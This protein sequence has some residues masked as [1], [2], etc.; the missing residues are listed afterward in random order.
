MSNGESKRLEAF[1][2]EETKARYVAAYD[3]LLRKWPIG[4]E[5]RDVQ[6]RYGITHVVVSGPVHAPPLVLL[7]AF[8]ATALV[9]RPNVEE[10]SRHF[11]VYAVDVVGQ[12]GKS[13]SCRRLRKRRDF[14]DW[15]CDLL[16]ALGIARASLVG[17]SYGGF[18]AM[19][20]A[21]L[22]PE[23]VDR[24]V[25]INPGGVFASF[26]PHLLKSIA[27]QLLRALRLIPQR[28]PSV[29][30]IL[31]RNV[32]FGADEQQWA[33]LV[34]LLWTNRMRINAIMPAV[35]S[36]AELQAIRCPALLLVGDDELLYDPYKL[37]PR[38]KQRMPSLEAEIVAGA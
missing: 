18:I 10:L 34:S 4:Y 3:A 8:M 22:A 29:A 24:V 36:R 32:H 37:V 11:R 1:P 31:G 5:E 12:F 19:N 21:S 17:N 35:F 28:K 9:W 15:M 27:L 7:H 20:Q 13:V 38:A 26:A 2:S 6:T 23:R 16:D 30:N 25:L 33:D 14:A